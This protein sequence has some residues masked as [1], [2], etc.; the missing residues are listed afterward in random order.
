MNQMSTDN[1]ANLAYT[2][3]YSIVYTHIVA[4]THRYTRIQ[5]DILRQGENVIN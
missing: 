4:N 2:Y 5:A 3:L 1:D